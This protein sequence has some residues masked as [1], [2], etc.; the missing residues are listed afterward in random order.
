MQASDKAHIEQDRLENVLLMR[1]QVLVVQVEPN[2]HG[3]GLHQ[4]SGTLQDQVDERR[5]N[6]LLAAWHGGE[7]SKLVGRIV[8]FP[9]PAAADGV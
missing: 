3:N 7:V 8:D 5:R 2:R 9:Q 6:G 1:R 4:F